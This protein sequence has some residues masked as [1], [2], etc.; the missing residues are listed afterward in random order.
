[1]NKGQNRI[2]FPLDVASID[3]AKR[4]IEL[5]AE[6]V[7]L[8]KIGLELFIRSG[9]D[10]IRFINAAGSTGIFLDLKLHDIPTT[11]ARAM[12]GIADLEIKFATVHC[13]ETQ[14]MLEAA[15]AASQGKVDILG[16]TVLTSVS[17]EDIKSA[18]YRSDYYPDMSEL[19]LKRAHMAKSTGCAGVVCSGRE[20][21]MIKQNLGKEFIAVTPGIRP[22]WSIGETDDQQRI[23]TPARAVK[24]G[25]DYLVIGRP[26]KDAGDP[27]DAAKRVAAEILEAF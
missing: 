3:E 27:V 14:K 13:G 17:S 11:V 16:V 23:T 15:V 26:I 20:V 7:G 10:I 22:S 9:P 24:D 8:F 25:A 1:M 5:L 6:H 21:R 2:I 18:G 19:V 4:Y 12:A